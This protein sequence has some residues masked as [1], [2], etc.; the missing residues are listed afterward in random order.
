MGGQSLSVEEQARL[1]DILAENSDVYVS[2]IDPERRI[3]Y[4]SRGESRSPQDVVGKRVED[5]APEGQRATVVAI[6]TAAF[7]TEEPQ[8]HAYDAVL[9]DG[10]R[11]S[12]RARFIPFRLSD[13][14]RR[15]LQ[16]TADETDQRR[17]TRELEESHGFRQLVVENLPDFVSLVDRERRFLWVSRLA[18]GLT[19]ED[20]LGAT[21][22]DYTSP[23]TLQV[24]VAAIERAFE[25]NEPQQFEARGYG[26]RA[27]FSRVVP[28]LSSEQVAGA[29]PDKVLLITSDVSALKQAEEAL[30]ASEERLHQAQR[31]ESVGQLA[32]GIA[33]DFNNLLQ[34][35]SGNLYFAQQNLLQGREFSDEL[36]Q[37]VVATERAAELTSHLLAIGRRKR[38][39]PKCVELSRSVERSVR[40]L[41]RVIPENVQLHFDP[42]SEPCRVELDIPQFEQVLINLCVNAR[43]AMPH[44]GNLR[45]RIRRCG[46]THVELSVADDGEGISEEN[47][48]RLFEPFFSTKGTGSGLGLAVVA[49]IVSAHGGEIVAKSELG[50]GTTF[51]IRLPLA[52]SEVAD[53]SVPPAPPRTGNEV[54]LVAEDEELVRRQAVRVLTEAGYRVIEAR[55]GAEAVEL[56][57]QHGAGVDLLL[58]DVIMPRLNGWEAYLKIEKNHPDVK[59]VFCTGYAASVLP[60]DIAQRGTRLLS[61]PYQP[62]T[63]LTL[64]REALDA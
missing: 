24:L 45:V 51:V 56:Y 61:K 54:V 18:P 11:R 25:T 32:G 41:R 42:G 36:N 5:F 63:L 52:V 64:V 20:V 47:L 14:Q 29:E 17:L 26:E 16:L 2:C 31:M 58:F 44:G 49:G 62:R 23:D 9:A 33:H 13:G 15:I 46:E 50:K 6:V 28:L 4:L 39:H 30:R 57:Q 1:F 40:M 22:D 55:D 34:I 38:V 8:E 59:V 12:M 10:S 43:D 19:R 21:V 35:I 37:A 27:Y 7:E 3:L 48:P 53:S 60:E